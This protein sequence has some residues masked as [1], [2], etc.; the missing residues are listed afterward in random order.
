M[1]FNKPVPE[2]LAHFQSTSTPHNKVLK[3]LDNVSSQARRKARY[4]LWM[5]GGLWPPESVLQEKRFKALQYIEAKL[6][7]G[8]FGIVCL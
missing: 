4:E 6:R 5:A 2:A 7:Y 1:A 3:Y 8:I